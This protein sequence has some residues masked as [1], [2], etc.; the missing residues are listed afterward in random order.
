[1]IGQVHDAVLKTGESVAIKIQRPNIREKVFADLEI[2]QDLASL[3]EHQLEW[4]ARYQLK[5]IIKEF[6]RSLRAE[7]DYT[8]EGL[9]A[10]KIANQYKKQANVRIPEIYWDYSTKQVITIEFIHGTKLN[11]EKALVDNN[12]NLDIFAKR[13]VDTMF[14]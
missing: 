12:I 13:L 3:A 11:Q 7:L 6:S 10:E 4:A 2:L 8:N 14:Y 1:S 5:D 9:N